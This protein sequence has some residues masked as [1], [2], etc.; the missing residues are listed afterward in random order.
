M[1]GMPAVAAYDERLGGWLTD[2]LVS[3]VRAVDLATLKPSGT[4]ECIGWHAC[5][6]ATSFINCHPEWTGRN[7]VAQLTHRVSCVKDGTATMLFGYDGPVRV[8]LDGVE[9]F[10]DPL[11]TNPA[12][13]DARRIPLNLPA[14]DH[15]LSVAIDINQGRAWGIYA[16]LEWKNP[17]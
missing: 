8:F 11:G 6:A 17:A 2:W 12:A 3:S 13:I 5:P 9:I 1:P 4:S 7:G 16:R 14:G 10:S 15:E